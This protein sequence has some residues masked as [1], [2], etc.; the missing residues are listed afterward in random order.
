MLLGGDEMGRTQQGNNNAWCQDNE[1]SWFDWEV[2]ESGER[3][4][5]FTRRLIGLRRDH[6]VF[7]R[8]QFLHGT[9]QEGSGLP[10]VWWF[11]P[12]GRRMT[13]R[14]WQEF[15]VVGMFLN[16]EE[17]A[18]PDEQGRP[19]VDESF[20]L[21]FNGSHEDIEFKLPPTRFGRRW[22]AVLRT[23]DPDAG[24][25]QASAGERLTLSELSLMLLRR[26]N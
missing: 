22:T 3:L 9:E 23:D 12:D 24:A 17:I 15:H 13:K 4:L 1:I 20:L 26:E 5:D 25:V 18:A 11:R 19:V 2:D 16:G 8:R 10:D 21:L 7:R 6:P 14:D